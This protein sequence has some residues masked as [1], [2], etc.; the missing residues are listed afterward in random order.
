MNMPPPSEQRLLYAGKQLEDERTLASY[1][2][3]SGAML[4]LVMRL[5]GGCRQNL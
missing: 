4:H 2:I 3:T 1:N 5:R